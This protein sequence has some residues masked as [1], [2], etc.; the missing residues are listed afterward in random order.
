LHAHRDL[1]CF[2]D[3]LWNNPNP[4]P[5]T[6]PSA[7]T[8]AGELTYNL[9]LPFSMNFIQSKKVE[10]IILEKNTF[11]ATTVLSLRAPCNK[12]INL[13]EQYIFGLMDSKPLKTTA[14]YYC[15]LQV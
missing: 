3:S 12:K 1:P 13:I 4:T 11:Y 8:E 2:A 14:E 9:F 7:N 5:E 10:P 6:R 15:Q